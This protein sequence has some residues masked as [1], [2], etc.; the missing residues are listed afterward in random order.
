MSK[1]INIGFFGDGIWAINS[2]KELLKIKSIKIK[3]ICPRYKKPDQNLIKLASNKNIN[4]IKL[5]NVN[6]KISI[7]LIKSLNIDLI[8]SM[9]YNQIF[10][11][12]IISLFKKKIINCHAGYLPFYRGRS[13]LNWVLINDEK[14]F[15]ITAHYINSKIDGGDIIF[16]K[17]F[18]IRDQDNY[19][20]ILNKAYINCPK[21]LVKAIRL[22]LNKKVKPIK[23]NSIDKKGSY[24]R[25]RISGDE[26]IDWSKNSR[27]IYCF[28][29]ALSRPSVIATTFSNKRKITIN[30]ADIVRVK[31]KNNYIPGTIIKMTKNFFIVKTINSALKVKEWSGT[32]KKGTVFK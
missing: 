10:K 27:E 16:Q 11:K 4:L 28:I 13:P 26:I 19:L 12:K 9:S 30:K 25:K 14:F 8:I 2:V 21:V 7:R 31:S 17:K 15:G 20:S 24:Y 5:K 1:K 23:Q 32:V 3:F 29:R 6:H 18:L 22:I